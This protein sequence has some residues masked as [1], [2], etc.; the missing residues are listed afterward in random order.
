MSDANFQIKIGVETQLAQLKAME[1]Q[2]EKQIVQLRTLGT[3]GA[4]ALKKVE[5]NLSLVRS[6]LVQTDS[7]SG[8]MGAKSG[9]AFKGV[10]QAVGQAGYQMQD[11]AVQVAGGQS[12]LTAFAQQGSQL[13]G[14]FGPTG[15]IAG[16]VLAVG[17]L[18]VKILDLGANT[19]STTKKFKTQAEAIEA[20]LKA[21]RALR[22]IND[23]TG[24]KQSASED[25]ATANLEYQKQLRVVSDLEKK[26]Q[27]A[28]ATKAE[29]ESGKFA[30]DG[31]SSYQQSEA[32]QA[33]IDSLNKKLEEARQNAVN[34]L[35]ALKEAQAIDQKIDKDLQ[36][37]KDANADMA[38]SDEERL[39]YMRGQQQA[40]EALGQTES[41]EYVQRAGKIM[42]LEKQLSDEQFKNV[43]KLAREQIN[44]QINVEDS[45]RKQI[46][47]AEKLA[48][49][50]AEK[51][52]T[53]R[54][55]QVLADAIAASKLAIAQIEADRLLDDVAKNEKIIP[56]LEAQNVAIQKRIDL[57]KIE[58]GIDSNP[59]SVQLRQGKVEKLTEQQGDN[60]V[61]IGKATPLGMGGSIAAAST[62]YMSQVGTVADQVGRA[63]SKVGQGMSNSLGTAFSDM[64]LKATSFK[65]AMAGFGNA[66][67]QSMVQAMAAMAADF[68]I[69]HT[70]MAA[71][72]SIF[73]A[74]DVAKTTLATGAK[75][76][77]HTGGEVAQTSATAAGA[78]TRTGIGLWE[79]ITHGLHV[80]WR[81]ATHIAGEIAKT[82]ATIF[83]A[84]VRIGSIIAESIANVWNAAIGA[85]SAMASIPWVGPILAVAAMGA[86]LGVGFAAVSNIGKFAEGGPVS[87]A[88]TG[89]SDSIPAW[90]SNGEYVMP[91]AETAKYRPLLD[92][93]RAGTLNPG[94][95]VSTGSGGAASPVQA[96][97]STQINI[98]LIGYMS[99][100]QWAESQ[101]GQAHIL[102]IVA[103]NIHTITG[104][105]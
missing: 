98:G 58:N 24:P 73:H 15:I 1:A 29:A 23:P 53:M 78:A 42:A 57:L 11:F 104:T 44:L 13:L 8:A 88:G 96:G 93:M 49:A 21:N 100:Q 97:G 7:A 41:V 40:A 35:P 91:A 90:L 101:E 81:T 12:A 84:G 5:T 46:Q 14:I 9:M 36:S 39:N 54:A 99:P 72:R 80:A 51:L 87:G 75:V 74:E 50:E 52:A 3:G 63:W 27:S 55:D 47:N 76:A 26:L 16:A 95:L 82:A 59:V 17:V 45:Q 6:A 89:T 69:Q 67:L 103:R 85:L 102:D 18:A 48:K 33:I 31:V 94:Q 43:G 2:F 60:A 10:G 71:V 25:V 28:K 70:V 30:G 20:L 4:D 92:S 66:I 64:I 68:I 105:G 79:T 34:L 83:G 62:S 77:I 37:A 65:D 32:G 61:T 56:L 19:E 86:M 38:R 22:D